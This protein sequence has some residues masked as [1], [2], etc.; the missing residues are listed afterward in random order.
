MTRSF[1]NR[2]IVGAAAVLLAC[3]V[4]TGLNAQQDNSK[5]KSHSGYGVEQTKPL[6]P[7][8]PAPRT[9]DGHPDLSGHWYVGLLGKENALLGASGATEG[10][11]NIRPFDPK[12]TPEDKPSFQP[13]VVEKLTK[14]GAFLVNHGADAEFE[15]LSKPQMLAAID[16]EIISLERNCMPRGVP[17]MF[18]EGAHGIQ[19]VQSPAFLAQLNELNHDYRVIPLDGRPHP[20]DPDPQYNGD[21]TAH[22]EGDTLV[23]DTVAIDERVWN[24][25]V[26][27]IHSDR[28]HV[29]ERIT[30]PSM[31]Y[32]NYQVTIEDPKVL[33]KPW[34]SVVH[35]F[36]L[37]HEPLLEWYCG[38]TPNDDENLQDLRKR[39][40][41]LEH[42]N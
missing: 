26:W 28:E 21:A 38:I 42:Q 23:I 8:G 33:T 36:S 40:A 5:P 2:L 20:K 35:H 7:G 19:L 32:L 41:Q 34:N 13:W 6:P 11:P 17:A 16:A 27:Q 9:A 37:S 12:V 39:K 31:N 24:S 18:L 22:W 14:A 3:M 4:F 25:Y 1:V 30:R 29:I 10:D 15:K